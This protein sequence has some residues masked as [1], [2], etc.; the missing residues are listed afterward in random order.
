M[1]S[2]WAVAA[3]LLVSIG[4]LPA[5]SADPAAQ[6]SDAVK[7]EQLEQSLV[8]R[9]EESLAKSLAH[10]QNAKREFGADYQYAISFSS[11]AGF[12]HRT[13]IIVRGDKVVERR[14]STVNDTANTR[15]NWVERTGEIGQHSEGAPA[16]KLE[17]LYQ[18][19]EREVL[20]VAGSSRYLRVDGRQ[21]L[22]QCVYIP[23]NCADD[24][25]FGIEISDL[26]F[27]NEEVK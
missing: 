3:T 26:Q 13:D 27:A 20:S 21:L 12:S 17:Q 2:V 18:K 19:C 14:F 22:R 8:Q 15:R 1:R 9:L 23:D 16:L 25:T 4:T 11:W 6:N 5:Y 7:R 10:W 24:C